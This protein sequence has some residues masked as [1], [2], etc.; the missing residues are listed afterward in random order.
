MKDM[1]PS[2]SALEGPKSQEGKWPENSN[3]TE[4]DQRRIYPGEGK[5][6]EDN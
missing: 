6:F 1:N 5:V 4:I 2:L 3:P